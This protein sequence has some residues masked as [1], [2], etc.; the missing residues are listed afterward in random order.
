MTHT[1]Q[2]RLA[3]AAAVLVV[4]LVLGANAHLL[5]VALQSQQECR[6]TADKM[7]ARR[8]C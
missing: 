5:T 7:P 6:E 8:A 3:T 1:A 2:K 4:L